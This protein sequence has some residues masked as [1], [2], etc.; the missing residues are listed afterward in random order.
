MRK[1]KKRKKQPLADRARSEFSE[2][3]SEESV[4]L[5][6]LAPQLYQNY[7]KGV[8]IYT[9]GYPF[10]YFLERCYGPDTIARNLLASY[11]PQ[12][13]LI[14]SQLLAPGINNSCLVSCLDLS[15]L[16]ERDFLV[17]RESDLSG[18]VIS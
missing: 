9:P 16:D 14:A 11:N 10:Y 15:T 17:P 2:N 4:S 8:C 3:D 18:Y 13:Q 6:Y 12:T 1:A 7:G 5:K